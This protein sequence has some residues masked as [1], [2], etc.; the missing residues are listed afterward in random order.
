MSNRFT[1]ILLLFSLLN[2][3]LLPG[4]K[5]NDVKA[6]EAKHAF[7]T[8][9][10][11]MIGRPDVVQSAAQIDFSMI[12]HLNLAFVNPDSAGHFA[13]NPIVHQLVKMAH[14]ANVKVLI[15]IG[16]GSIP[17]YFVD[18]LAD[19]KRAAFVQSLVTAAEN[20]EVDG[21]DVDLEGGSINQYY[22][23]FVK[24]L[25]VEMKQRHKLLS[26]A[27]ATVYGNAVPN[28]ALQYFDFI[29]IMSY[30]K[31]GPWNPSNAG[32]HSP[33]DMAVNDLAYWSNRSANKSK[34]VLG[35]PFYGYGFGANNVT[36][37]M[38]YSA[39]IA[40]F[41]GA[42]NNDQLTMTD[43]E[44]MY[45]NGIPTI[46]NKTT[47]ALQQ[48]GGVMIWELLQ[49]APGQNSLLKNIHDVIKQ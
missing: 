27:V 23:A 45:Y 16:G 41:A 42:E 7:K 11:I 28:E 3:S 29:N 39:I 26:A 18:Y 35:V 49:D 12:T 20:Y 2:I 33:Y 14:A 31:T 44:I 34:L 48:G 47:L 43:G 40:A 15:S 17:V 6:E 32:P 9:G 38:P 25:S 24:A 8:V 1:Y 37:S 4:C 30:D 10:Y 19:N 46:K 5:K 36:S 22:T 21:I 13:D